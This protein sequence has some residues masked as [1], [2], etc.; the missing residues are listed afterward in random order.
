MHSYCNLQWYLYALG[1]RPLPLDDELVYVKLE[2]SFVIDYYLV[3]IGV[4]L[5]YD[6]FLSSSPASLFPFVFCSYII[7]CTISLLHFRIINN[8]HSCSILLSFR[9]AWSASRC[10]NSCFT[11]SSRSSCSLPVLQQVVTDIP[12]L[13]CLLYFLISL[14]L[15]AH[16]FLSC[17]SIIFLL[18]SIW[19]RSF[20]GGKV[21][22]LQYNLPYYYNI[23]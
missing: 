13:W 17:S 20:S 11:T 5:W 9:A 23:L 10:C 3:C 6:H 19:S 18:F 2:I 16:S 12:T 4:Y 21:A 7:W 22:S 14:S 8:Y 15:N 1:C